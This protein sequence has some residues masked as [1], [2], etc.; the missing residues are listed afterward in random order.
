MLK[1]F[2]IF[3][4]KTPVISILKILFFEKVFQ[5]EKS[6]IFVFL[7]LAFSWVFHN[8]IIARMFK[9]ASPPALSENILEINLIIYK[10]F[11]KTDAKRINFIFRYAPQKDCRRKSC[12]SFCIRTTFAAEMNNRN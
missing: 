12:L 11:R 3:F 9:T 5:K 4:S 7:I 1:S 8:T 10:S 2:F 6:I